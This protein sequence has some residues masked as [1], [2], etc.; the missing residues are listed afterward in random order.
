MDPPVR[1]HAAVLVDHSTDISEGDQVV[2]AGPPEAEDL[3]VALFE[4][5]GERDANPV[6]LGASSRAS[7]GRLQAADPEKFGPSEHV[8]ALF[9]AMDAY[10]GIRSGTNINEMGDVDP[11][12]M[13]AY[14]SAQKEVQEIRLGKTWCGTQYPSSGYAQKAEMSTEAY[15]EFVWNAINKDWDAQR[16]FQAQMVEILDP[17]EEVCIVSGEE[18]DLTMSIAGMNTVN[19]DGQKNLPGGEVFTAP[20]PDSVGPSCAS[21]LVSRLVS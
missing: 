10:I 7:S 11:E 15:E 8:E 5:C 17:A 12:T 6:W 18:T 20:V 2:I 13:T 4:A 19:D 16:E 1:Q 21:H 14:G 9:E 3:V